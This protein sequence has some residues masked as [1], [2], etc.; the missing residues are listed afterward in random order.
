MAKKQKYN[1][2][3][4]MMAVIE[5]A[6][7]HPGKIHAAKL[8]RWASENI[9]ELKGVR[10]YMFLRKTTTTTK[11]GKKI[12]KN[13][14]CSDKIE[15]INEARKTTA[16]I[17]TNILLHSSDPDD[18]LMLSR[19][20][21][22][23]AIIDTRSQVDKITKRDRQLNDENRLL[24]EEN[25]ELLKKTDLLETQCKEIRKEIAVFKKNLK[26]VLWKKVE[27]N[28]KDELTSIGIL[29]GGYDF[30]VYLRSL[31]DKSNNAYSFVNDLKK[32]VN[33]NKQ[34]KNEH[35]FDSNNTDDLTTG[36]DFGE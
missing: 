28:C 24:R 17:A 31:A 14:P 30:N 11:N 23:Q 36:I 16:S 3:L 34:E 15:E 21:Q 35:M 26:V 18:F 33:E 4:L 5:Y 10:D 12:I 8:A 19:S 2:D 29:D 7:T 6:K 32:L 9:P 1:D 27:S 25:S 22:R 20:Q 13:R